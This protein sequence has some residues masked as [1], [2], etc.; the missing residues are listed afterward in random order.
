M[1]EVDGM[2]GSDKGGT[3]IDPLIERFESSNRYDQAY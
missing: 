2:S 1:D 3:L